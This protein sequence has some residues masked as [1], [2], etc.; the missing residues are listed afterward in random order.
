MEWVLCLHDARLA[1]MQATHKPALSCGTN[2]V[3]GCKVLKKQ[4]RMRSTQHAVTCSC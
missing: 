3:W 4:I 2:V 1:V